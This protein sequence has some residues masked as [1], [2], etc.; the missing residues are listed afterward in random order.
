L[1]LRWIASIYQTEAWGALS[2]VRRLTM[3][4]HKRLVE[5]GLS[6]GFQLPRSWLSGNE[7]V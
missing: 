7:A 2:R 4:A 5:G 3:A 1:G 6:G